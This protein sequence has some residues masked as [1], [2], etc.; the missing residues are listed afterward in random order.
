[1]AKKIAKWA[2]DNGGEHG[3]VREA[4]RENARIAIAA[5]VRKRGMPIDPGMIDRASDEPNAHVHVVTA[6]EAM[7]FADELLPLLKALV[8]LSKVAE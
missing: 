4:D 8:R 2:D 7:A 1:M 3:S 5:F 6:D